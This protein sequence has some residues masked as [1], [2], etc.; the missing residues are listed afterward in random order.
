VAGNNADASYKLTEAMIQAGHK[1]IG[2][3]YGGSIDVY[4]ERLR[5]YRSA[6]YANGLEYDRSI[7]CTL[8]RS[9][10][11]VFVDEIREFLQ[12]IAKR[13]TPAPTAFL[14]SD[15]R[16]AVSFLAASRAMNMEFSAAGFDNLP[17]CR[18]QT[19]PLASAEVDCRYTGMTAAARMIDKIERNDHRTQKIYTEISVYLRESIALNKK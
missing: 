4:R 2:Y 3:I 11:S 7:V 17:L 19:P 6:L 18:E 5:G 10:K 8:D 15:D 14:M 1:R 16:I 9:A 13:N 12:K